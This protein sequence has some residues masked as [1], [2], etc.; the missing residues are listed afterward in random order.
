MVITKE[1]LIKI[2]VDAYM[3]SIDGLDKDTLT[4]C[5]ETVLKDFPIDWLQTIEVDIEGVLLEIVE[6]YRI[7][8]MEAYQEKLLN[9]INVY[10]FYSYFY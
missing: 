6:G 10:Q 3:L 5:V 2:L 4:K 8:T 9:K 1:T 7:Q